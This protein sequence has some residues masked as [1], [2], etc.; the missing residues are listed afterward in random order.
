[1][2]KG[3][4]K[5]QQMLLTGVM[6]SFISSSLIMFILAISRTHDLQGIIFWVMGSLQHAGRGLVYGAFAVSAAGLGISYLYCVPLNAFALG[7]EEALHL[8][9]N[10]E[11]TKKALFILSALLTGLSVSVAG[12]IGFIGLVVPHLLRIIVGGDHRILLAS[13][14]LAGAVFLILCDMLARVLISPLELPV[15][16]I[17][18]IIGGAIF[19]YA[20]S[21]RQ[22]RI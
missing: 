22:V 1:V 18:G 19:I 13:S 14:F 3:A 16:V 11:K 6:I 4:V 15:G 7:E 17:T 21:R 2:R 12:V 20:L 9:V 8:G 5:I 10:V